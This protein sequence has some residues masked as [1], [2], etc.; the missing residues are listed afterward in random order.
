MSNAYAV[1]VREICQVREIMQLLGA[2]QEA[3]HKL[4][5]GNDRRDALREIRGFQL[6]AAALVRRLAS[7]A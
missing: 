5:E 1:E 6:R 7:A 4:P 3:A 2:L